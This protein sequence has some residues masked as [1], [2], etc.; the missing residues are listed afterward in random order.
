MKGATQVKEHALSNRGSHSEEGNRF[1]KK[2]K[3]GEKQQLPLQQKMSPRTVT[4]EQVFTN[5]KTEGQHRSRSEDISS[6]LTEERN[7]SGIPAIVIFRDNC[8]P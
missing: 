3:T 5:N 2:R 4:K 6:E 1:G 7:A 8:R